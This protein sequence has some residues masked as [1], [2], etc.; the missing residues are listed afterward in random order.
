VA[1]L[2]LLII[3]WTGRQRRWTDRGRRRLL[4]W[5]IVITVFV[6]LTRLYFFVREFLQS[7]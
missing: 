5:L 4:G 6:W 1:A 7:A 3:V 2:V